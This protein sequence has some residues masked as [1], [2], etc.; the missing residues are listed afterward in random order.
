[1]LTQSISS[2][3]YIVLS[4]GKKMHLHICAMVQGLSLIEVPNFFNNLRSN[5][6][7]SF[8]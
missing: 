8:L 7:S 6:I 1:M 4:L 5:K 2:E 3:I